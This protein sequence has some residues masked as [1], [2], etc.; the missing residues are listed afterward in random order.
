MLKGEKIGGLFKLSL[1]SLHEESYTLTAPTQKDLQRTQTQLAGLHHNVFAATS[2]S[3]LTW[4]PTKALEQSPSVDILSGFHASLSFVLEVPF[5]GWFKR[6][7][8]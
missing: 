7:P 5:V 4:N 8:V 1:A 3:A 6:E 2:A